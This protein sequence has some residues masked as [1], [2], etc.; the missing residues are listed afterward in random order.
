MEDSRSFVQTRP[1]RSWSSSTRPWA[2]L[3]RESSAGVILMGMSSGGRNVT[4]VADEIKGR[5]LFTY[6]AAIDAAFNDKSDP[7]INSSVSSTRSENFFQTVGNDIVPGEEFHTAIPSFQQ[8]VRL[9]RFPSLEKVAS[10]LRTAATDRV[11][12]GLVDKAHEIAVR[13]GYASAKS[14]ALTILRS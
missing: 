8:N 14:T 1:R 5:R 11:K 3:D 4:T 2:A 12:R 7:A 9:D 6:V 10:F 13:H